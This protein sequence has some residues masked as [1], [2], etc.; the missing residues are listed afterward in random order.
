MSAPVEVTREQFLG[1]VAA[2]GEVPVLYDKVEDLYQKEGLRAVQ[3][4]FVPEGTAWVW[5]DKL[6]LMS[7][8]LFAEVKQALEAMD[9]GHTN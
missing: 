5:E 2:T 4:G 1:Y 9:A 8:S 6:C 3:S 7:K